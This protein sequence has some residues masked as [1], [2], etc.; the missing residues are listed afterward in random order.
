MSMVNKESQTVEHKQNWR[1]DYLKVVSAFANSDGGVLIVGLDDIGK[2]S[3]LKNAKKLLEDIPN[4]IRNKLGIIP[5]VELDRKNSEDIIKIRI[6][7]STVPISHNGKYYIR[8]G[9]T[10]QE[11]QGKDL[12]DFLLRKTG[13][14]WDDAIEERGGWDLLEKS[15][16]EDFKRY[17]VD[18]IPSIVRETDL[19]AILQK[20][21]LIENQHLKR[22]A[23]LLFGND[24]QR[25]YSHACV[26]IGLFLTNT[27]IQTTDIVKGN[28]FQQL[29]SSLEILRTKYLQS[30]IKFEGIHRRDI[31]E[32]PYEALREAIINALIHRDYQ[33]FSQI[34]IRVYP[35]KLIIMN[36]GSLPPEVPVESLK[37]NHLSRPRNKLLA[38]TFYYAGFIEAWGR[39]TL[40]ILEKC[41]EQDLPEPD[42]TEENGVMTVTFYKDKWNKKNLKKLGLNERQIKAVGHIKENKTINLSSYEGLIK[43]ISEKTLYRDLQ[44]LV[45]KKILKEI[46]EKKGRKYELA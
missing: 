13:I 8:S 9:S 38:E 25:I 14:T 10:V 32:Y 39:G 22:A 15:T 24:T 17:A 3:G 45:D 27:D 46:G 29:E 40:K 28:L 18:R 4:T 41:A 35:D 33:S 30:K 2:P 44:D 34:Q 5:S 19:A 1:D 43:N 42:F 21:N 12:A 16:I 23:I 20:L 31:L 6:L 11:L 7:S 26:K 36:A 37:T